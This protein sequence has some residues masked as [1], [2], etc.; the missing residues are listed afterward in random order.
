MKQTKPLTKLVIVMRTD[1]GLSKGMLVAAG[2]R[3]SL[4]SYKDVV[5]RPQ[6]A[7]SLSS[8]FKCDTPQICLR[9]DSL[10]EL[11]FIREKAL[12]RALLCHSVNTEE[13]ELIC[14][15]IGPDSNFII[16]EVTRNLR[17]L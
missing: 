17:L 15:S 11:Q 5:F 13:G 4:K 16:D 9:V 14:T 1:L 12:K 8:W 2:S 6:S 7:E 3:A 10:S